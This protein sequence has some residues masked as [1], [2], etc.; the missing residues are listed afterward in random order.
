MSMGPA[1]V[2]ESVRTPVAGLAFARLTYVS[3]ANPWGT[4]QAPFVNG[5]NAVPPGRPPLLK[6]QLVAP[7]LAVEAKAKF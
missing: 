2:I 1:S 5:V 7:V 4:V 3:P 6:A